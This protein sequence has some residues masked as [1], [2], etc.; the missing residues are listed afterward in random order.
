MGRPCSPLAPKPPMPNTDAVHLASLD[1]VIYCF[2]VLS[3]HY[4][5]KSIEKNFNPFS[6]SVTNAHAKDQ[7]IFR[8]SSEAKL[9]CHAL[10]LH[11][12]RIDPGV[13]AQALS[14]SS[15]R[16][17]AKFRPFWDGTR[18]SHTLVSTTVLLCSPLFV[19]W[20][21]VD[22]AGYPRLRGCIGTL[23]PR[24][25]PKALKDYALTR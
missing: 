6:R 3:G 17:C 24:P 1:H 9:N 25:L 16:S 7:A 2:D 18:D 19:T 12:S 15:S 22:R 21:K 10:L 4:G 5:G 13:I 14:L 11:V 20:N 8:N 23:E